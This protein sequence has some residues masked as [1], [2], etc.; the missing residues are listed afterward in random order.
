MTVKLLTEQY[1]E[2]LSIIE[3]CTGSYESTLV[4]MPH[5]WKSRVTAQLLFQNMFSE[6][7]NDYPVLMIDGARWRAFWWFK[8]NSEWPKCKDDVLEGTTATKIY[9]LY[10][11]CLHHAC[12]CVYRSFYLTCI[13][14]FMS[15]VRSA[16]LYTCLSIG[17][18]ACVSVFSNCL[19]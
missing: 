12:Q 10:P 17:L 16:T 8:K 14:L 2:F 6:A 11:P 4:K 3:G 13:S 19:K 18:S 7:V 1:L 5:C 9:I 15:I